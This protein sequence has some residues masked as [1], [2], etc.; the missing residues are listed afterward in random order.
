MKVSPSQIKQELWRR[1]NLEWLLYPHQKPIYDR[2]RAVLA[3]DDPGMSSYV[4]DCARQFGK[5]FTEI[6]VCIEESIRHPGSTQVFVAPMK[7]QAN[8]IIYGNTLNVILTDCPDDIKPKIGDS[9]IEF[10]NGSRI[11][12]AGTDNR[13]YENLRGG[14][15]HNVFLDEAGFMSNL[16]DGVLAVVTPMTKTTDGKIIFSS[17][18]P[19]ELDHDYYDVLRYHEEA[20]LISTYTIWDDRTLTEKQLQKIINSCRG[21]DTVRFKREFE[22]KRIADTARQV[23]PEF[24]MATAEIIET[25]KDPYYNYWHRYVVADWGGRDRTAIL[26]AHYN[27]HQRKLIIEDYLDYEGIQVVPKTI[28]EGI[29]KKVQALWS[30]EGSISYICD[31]NNPILQQDMSITYR[32]NFV[33]TTKGSLEQMVQRVRDWIYESRIAFLEPARHVASCCAAANWTRGRDSFATSKIYGHYDAAA[34]LVY[35][36]RNTNEHDNPV[37]RLHNFNPVLQYDSGTLE[38]VRTQVQALNAVF[39][40]R[41]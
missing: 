9:A 12:I 11:R 36:V 37:P 27:H 31:S 23:F 38:P 39:S 29:R 33:P 34:A 3:S 2:I 30:N 35:L 41:R 18:P 16:N 28:A 19:E 15:A 4:I 6:L 26:F 10:P 7:S 20:G 22:C 8:E 24:T 5:S 21:Q 14:A 40:P 17:T 1:G 13:N 25:L 32:L